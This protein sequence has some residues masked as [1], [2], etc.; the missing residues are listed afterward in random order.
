MR[1]GWLKK[2][3]K[4]NR[5]SRP[6][7]VLLTD[8]S[9]DQVA[10]R[11]TG[12][13][14]KPEV[15]VS[16]ED[17]WQPQGKC[18]VREAELDKLRKGDAVLLN[19]AIRGQLQEWWLVEGKGSAKTPSWDIASTC[20]VSGRRGLLLVE[21]KAHSEELSKGDRCGAGPVNRK[22]IEIALKEASAGLRKATRGPWRLSAEH[23]FQL[24][25]RFAW[26]WKLATFGVLVV[27]VYLGFLDAIEMADKNRRPFA[28][29]DDWRTALLKDCRETVDTACW[30]RMLD[31]GGT[32][33]LPLMRSDLQPFEPA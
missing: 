11:L 7:C 18:H 2:L 24:A 1:T 6:R 28:S 5:G 25:N 15:Q 4:D 16:A 27:L 29:D 14:G 9:A 32:P 30:E 19:D 33:L 17:R 23:R 21:A 10:Q 26:S 3:G 31:I 20:T 8:G 13:V 12:L 22:R